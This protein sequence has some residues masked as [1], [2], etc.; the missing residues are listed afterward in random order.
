MNKIS[1][2]EQPVVIYGGGQIGVGFCRRLMQ[3]GVNVCA[4]IDR[5][6]EGVSNAPVPVMNVETC[7]QMHGD[8]LV[9]V[10]IGNGLAHPPIART[11]RSVGYTK[12]LHLPAFLRGEKAAAMTRAWNAFYSGDYAVPFASFD[13]L[14]TVHAGDYLLSALSDY[15]TAIVH[16]DYVYT[17]RRSYDGIDHDY[18][19]YFKWQNQ[20]QDVI[21]RATNVRLDDPVVKALLPFNELF[22]QAQLDF[23]RAK[24]FFDMG[25]Y[26][27][28]AASVAVFDSAA[29]RFNI[30]DGSHRAFYLERQ[31]FDGIPLKMKRAEWEAYF[32]AYQAQALMD[33]C[34]QLQSLPVVVTHPAFMS[35]PVRER[36]P[37]AEFLRL[38]KG[39]CPV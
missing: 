34:R 6:P 37:D 16:K 10:A 38:L 18:A 21:D 20:E 14:Y 13:E 30:L 12:I 28:E 17:V 3:C 11:L 39:V 25:D 33:Y 24:T 7:I 23:Y 26:Y 31:G 9:F 4:I 29:H 5:N 19:D 32:R 35:F 22:T 2:I 8:A 15:V 36:E 27:R 1:T